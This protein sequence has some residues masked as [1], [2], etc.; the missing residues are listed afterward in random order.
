MS[1]DPPPP[2]N[3][4][5]PCGSGRRYKDCHGSVATPSVD[6]ALARAKA[7]FAAGDRGA[8]TR[9]CE[10]ALAGAPDHPA[11]MQ[12]LA[13]CA[14]EDGRPVAG[15]ELALGAV[16]GLATTLVAPEVAFGVWSTLN[17]M[18]TQALSG[19][20][21]ATASSQRDAYH[22][23]L[24]VVG[25]EATSLR[26]EVSV[27][28]VL[29]TGTTARDCTATLESLEAQQLLPTELCVV[30]VGEAAPDPVLRARLA[31]LPFPAR[32]LESG[33]ANY[34]AAVNAGVA[35]TAGNWL[36]TFAPP[37][38]LAPDHLR[39]LVDALS[40]RGA[41][42]GFSACTWEP[43]GEVPS[44]H[45]AARAAAGA[46]LQQ[47]IF[48]ADTVGFALIHQEFAAI[49]DGAM[50]W[51]RDLF[52]RV[53]G[54]RDLPGH[55]G[56]DFAMRALWM[57]EPWYT[58]LPTYRHRIGNDGPAQD[59]TAAEAA[60]LRLFRDYYTWACDETR[61]P[62]NEFA[63][64]LARWGLHS[65]KRIFQT[66]HLLTFD[67]PAIEVLAKRVA[68]AGELQRPSALTPGVNLVG[69]AYGE[70]GLGESLRALARAADAGAIPFTVKDVDQR[71]QARQ[72]DRSIA[73]HVSDSLRHRLSL[74]CLNPDML[75]PVLPVLQATRE[76]GGRSVGYW[77]W[78]LEHIPRAW[79]EAL[80][81]IDEVWCATEFIATAMRGA[82]A[83]PVIK[84]ALPIEFQLGRAYSR[85]DFSLPASPYLFLFTFDFNSFVKRKNPEAVIQ[86]FRAAFPPGRDDVG[87]VVKSINGAHR[88]E[89]VAAIRTL[90]AGDPRIIQIDRF[91]S[92]D[93]TY[94]LIAVCDSY[95]SLHRAEGLGLG[96]AEA[97]YL[98]KPVVGTAYSGNLEFM[99]EGN[100]ALVD[101]RTVPVM[102]GEYLYDDPRF[103]WAEVD[104]DDA[105]RHLRRL[106]DD[107]EWRTR[108][109]AAG[110]RDIRS[111]FTRERTAT[112]MRAR[113]VE[114]GALPP[115]AASRAT[116]F[117]S[118][119]QN[120]E[121]ALLARVL[122]GVEHGRYIDVGANDPDVHSVTRAFYDRGWSGINVEPV[123]ALH[124]RLA[125]ARTRDVNLA[126][127][128]GRCD[129][130]IVISEIAETGLSTADAEVAAH[131]ART[132]YPVVP[133]EVPL[134]MLD[135][136]WRRHVDGEIHFLKIDVEGSEADVLAGL[137]LAQR[138]PWIIV[139]EATAPLTGRPTHAGWEPRLLAARYRHAHDDGLNRYYVAEEHAGRVAAFGADAARVPVIR[140]VELVA[141]DE[142]LPPE[143]R[144]DPSAIPFLDA[145]APEPQLA[146]PAS[147]MC[148]ERQFREPAYAQWCR[149]LKEVPMLHRK[150]WEFVYAMQVLETA[151]L[152]HPGRRG[153]GFG[154]G[155][156]PLAA[157]IAARGCEVVA[158]DL[159]AAT[160]AGHGWVET[161][162][163]AA[164][165]DDL[166]DRGICP[167]EQFQQRVRFLHAD[168]NAIPEALSDFDFVW[169]CCAFEHLGSIEHGLA[170]V[171]R[172]M[173]CLRPGGIAVHTT[174]FNLSSNQRTVESRD[175]SVFRR[176]DLER[177]VRDLE[178]AGHRPWPL[179][180]N[181]GNGPLDR[182]VDLP[183]YR[184][185]PHVRLRLDRFVITS[186]GLVI[187]RAP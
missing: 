22:R 123:P 40:T 152:L 66:G 117:V 84:I 42:W 135:T 35:A 19:L 89:L 41:D 72:A 14:Y 26:G 147:Q 97:M 49:G 149:A 36:L 106:A 125:A 82:T 163:H 50:L 179:N 44:E 156:E 144:F 94:G 162:Q 57:A 21:T 128:A 81:A 136:I 48:E 24:D 43:T 3:A 88:P 27:V 186:I 67:L 28:L 110:Q 122:E 164:R 171:R 13:Q 53:G 98:G 54:F 102:P 55:A 180:F 7:Q 148:T 104:I 173:R 69:F 76:A 47:S 151:G 154:C 133:R 167:P 79:D 112:A 131:H 15:L 20:G 58:A 68:V 63:P 92:R 90:I 108:L 91:L 178:A 77:Y 150:Q 34:A 119:A 153:L 32:V 70:F 18:F 161:E 86:A 1:Q 145:S 177:L 142:A 8:A 175:L 75:K 101:Y 130:S 172:A 56:W 138:R 93:E 116:V 16:R 170:F 168:M 111:H 124:A 103:I 61:T 78:E 87:L 25:D 126:V 129:G 31:R 29:P 71:L 9:S 109:A 99:R 10:E 160:A 166:N 165:L 182:Y 169:S 137:D 118:F 83:K 140:A 80:A 6:D 132:G 174:E 74:L 4:P 157:L 64:S 65:L 134:L 100:S 17:F 95:V 38:A 115:P 46:T 183:P 73:G 114:L 5:C 51:S 12:I 33:A 187:Q 127:A 184:S 158:T 85:A 96:L 185:E 159:D 37:H 143:Q 59:R 39:S 2:R 146:A 120:G 52:E 23:R 62:P 113:M 141:G 121:D 30:T 139:V 45:I 11:A 107:P 181:P 105:A 155:R 60:Q 176:Q